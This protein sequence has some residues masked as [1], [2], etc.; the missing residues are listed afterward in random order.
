MT[1]D[2]PEQTL[3]QWLLRLKVSGDDP[4]SMAAAMMALVEAGA[5][6]VVLA[7]VARRGG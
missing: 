7:E 2:H 5:P 6:H 1:D 4:Q 3:E